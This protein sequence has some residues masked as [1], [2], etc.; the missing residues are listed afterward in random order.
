MN[1]LITVGDK[2]FAPYISASQIEDSVKAIAQSINESY[3]E[4]KA[5]VL[6]LVTL[7]GAMMFAAELSKYVT[8]PL[9]WAFVKCSSYGVGMTSSGTVRFT[10]QPTVPVE[11]RDVLVIED[12]VD[13][14]NTW[15]ALHSN[16]LEANAASVKIATMCIKRE[17]YDK[18]L[19]VDF[20]ALEIENKFIVGYGL[21][22]GEIGRNI[23]G[24]YVL[25][26]S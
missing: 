21:D 19:P 3:S 13:T 5:P 6:M 14:G 12:I 4:A 20:V 15:V 2:D 9:E 22:Y 25:A 26:T 17:V 23:N 7:S 8:I 1:Q 10:V 24:I 18:P 16:L 11:G